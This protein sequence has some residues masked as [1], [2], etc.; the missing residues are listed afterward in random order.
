[1]KKKVLYLM[2]ANFFGGVSIVIQN[3]CKGLFTNPETEIFL[4][5]NKNLENHY[6][7]IENIKIYTIDFTNKVKLVFYMKRII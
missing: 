5:V 3:I 4:I 2:T 6:R 1:M 7:G